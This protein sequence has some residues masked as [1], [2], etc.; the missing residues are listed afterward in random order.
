VDVLKDKC[1]IEN[2]EICGDE[3]AFIKFNK[4]NS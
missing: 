3:Q 1:I 2:G 4:N